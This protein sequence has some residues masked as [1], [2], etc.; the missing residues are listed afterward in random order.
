MT[1]NWNQRKYTKEEFK[2]AFSESSNWTELARKLNLNPYSSSLIPS[3]KKA[4]TDLNLPISHLTRKKKYSDEELYK[5]IVESESI[6]GVLRK[7]NLRLTGSNYNHISKRIKELEADISHFTGKSHNKGKIS[8]K[9]KTPEKVL[10]L[11]KPTDRRVKRE[12]LK[13]CMIEIGI[14]YICNSCHT[15]P[16][17]NEKKLKLEI[18]H[19]N[20]DF[21]DNR[22]D[23]LEFLCPNCHSQEI[24]SNK[25]YKYKNK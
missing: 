25:P 24:T 20:G 4:A 19:K 5:T 21:W 8:P 6:A 9:R 10:M 15:K 14:E 3:L 18:N 11:G 17:W 1:V 12:Q 13:R 2:K 23:N 22:R 16:F 7:L